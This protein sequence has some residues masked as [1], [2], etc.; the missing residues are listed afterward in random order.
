MTAMIKPFN[1]NSN[2]DDSDTS[3][4]SKPNT[5]TPR[6]HS[7]ITKNKPNVKPKTLGLKS[8]EIMH[9]SSLKKSLSNNNI[10]PPYPPVT[11]PHLIDNISSPPL[12]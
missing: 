7:N 6:K 2:S 4:H 1:S 8:K 11:T 3:P 9:R 12:T 10:S 5:I